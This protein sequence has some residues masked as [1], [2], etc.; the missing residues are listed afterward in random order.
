MEE[1]FIHYRD[2]WMEKNGLNPGEYPEVT[3][4]EHKPPAL[5]TIDDRA[6]RFDGEW[7]DIINLRKFKP[8]NEQET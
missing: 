6:L 8:W 1:W 2:V 5:I 3:F 7:P 4:P